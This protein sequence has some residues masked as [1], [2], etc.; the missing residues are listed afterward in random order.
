MMAE[1]VGLELDTGRRLLGWGSGRVDAGSDAR[2]HVET[3]SNIACLAIS[4]MLVFPITNGP[5]YR[6]QKQS[7]C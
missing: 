1:T 3:K 4:S 6:F 7:S 2:E 5:V